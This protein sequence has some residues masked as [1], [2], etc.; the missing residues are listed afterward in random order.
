MTKENLLDIVL[1]PYPEMISISELSQA[2]NISPRSCYRFVQ[3]KRI[4]HIRMEKKYLVYK[5]EVVSFLRSASA[6]NA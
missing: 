5:S 2:L 6:N 4:P 1:S 3:S